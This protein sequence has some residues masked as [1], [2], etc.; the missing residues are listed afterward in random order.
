MKNAVFWGVSEERIT[1]IIGVIIG[2][3]GILAITSN[4]STLRR[5]AD[6]NNRY[7]PINVG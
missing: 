1:S 3:L 2:E 7:M 6:V 4:G 5:Y